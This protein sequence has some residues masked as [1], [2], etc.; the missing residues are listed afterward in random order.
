MATD[1]CISISVRD[2]GI[3][4]PANILSR[5]GTA[6]EQASN[7]P[8]LAHEGTGL[9]LALVKALVTQHG[10]SLR[11]ESLEDVGTTVRVELPRSQASRAAA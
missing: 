6:F 1:D 7:D 9:G 4:I 2:T 3:G 5:I 8:M 10:G 11:V